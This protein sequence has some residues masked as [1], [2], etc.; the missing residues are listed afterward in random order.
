MLARLILLL[1]L[2]ALVLWGLNWFRRTPPQR[3]AA[4]LRKAA[5]YGGIGLLL[6]L[7]VTGRL[8]PVFAALAAAV[9]ALLR[10]AHLVRLLPMVQQLL[11]SLG[12]IGASGTAGAAG[13]G[14]ASSIRTRF[15]DMTL[16]LASGRMDGVVLEGHLSGRR[17]ADLSLDQILGLLAEYRAQD[18]QS[19]T[20][21]ETYLDRERGDAWRDQDQG[22]DPGGA[23]TGVGL[24]MDRDE[25]LRILGLAEGASADD[26]RAAHR[27]LMQRFHPD[28]GGSDY[29][30]AKINEAKRLL[31]G[32]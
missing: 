10:L 6:V 22:T 9:P 24:R 11:Q 28:R 30:A 17:L 18:T 26:I 21:L 5:L 31:L 1:A 25:A 3:V 13:G 14:Q 12:L 23:Q 2:V 7:V 32:D 16:D 19:A 27:R 20:L 29:L 4:A 15:L 8:N